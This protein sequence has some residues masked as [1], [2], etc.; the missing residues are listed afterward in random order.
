MKNFIILLSLLVVSLGYSQE[1]VTNGD[2]ETGDTTGWIGNAANVVTENGNSYNS[3]NV[4]TAGDPWNVNLSQVLEL[5]PGTTYTFSFDAWSDGERTIIA[6]IGQNEDPWDNVVETVTL[7]TTSQTFT[8]TMTAP[9]TVTANSRVI[10]DMGADTGFVGIDNVSLMEEEVTVLMPETA[11]PTPPARAEADVASVFSDAYAN[12]TITEW[13]PDWG[14]SSCRFNDATADSDPVK[15][16]DVNPGQTF[17]GIDFSGDPVDLTDF[18]HMHVDYWVDPIPT[19]LVLD[20]KLSNHADGAGETSAI[21]STQPVSQAG[22]WVSLDIL[23]DDFTAAAANGLL[24]REAIAQVVITAARADGNEPVDV[25]FDNIYF[26]KN[27]VL[28]VEDVSSSLEAV[29]VSPNPARAGQDVTLNLEADKV[30]QVGVYN[31]DGKLMDTTFNSNVVRTQKLDQ[32][33]YILN[34]QTTDGQIVNRKL[35]VR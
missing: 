5:T 35:I 7:S 8:Y 16:M 31:M 15:V 23:L 18:T 12:V 2:F 21:Q 26:H 22:E 27:T 34:I 30:S 24:D 9:A 1:L 20:F 17:G 29:A 3:A 4:A 14:P 13:G 11:A 32:G 25:Y 6:G 19:G 28:N 10:F 33:V